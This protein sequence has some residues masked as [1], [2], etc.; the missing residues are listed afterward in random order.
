MKKKTCGRCEFFEDGRCEELN[1]AVSP[2]MWACG[3][4]V[5]RKMTLKRLPKRLKGA[6]PWN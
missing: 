1:E 6:K 2:F 5:K 4:F 3:L